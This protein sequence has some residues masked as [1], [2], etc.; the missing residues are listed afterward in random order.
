M[1][2]LQIY[3]GDQIN[4]GATTWWERFDA[5]DDYTTSLSHGWGGS[6]TWFLTTYL[7]GAK[8]LGPNIWLVRPALTG[9]PQVSGKIPLR[10][11]ELQAHWEVYNDQDSMVEITAS[12]GSGGEIVVPYNDPTLILTLNGELIWKSQE[13]LVEDVY[14]TPGEIHILIPGG[15]YTLLIHQD[16]N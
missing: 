7:L 15:Q 13:A 8:R 2:I 14:E 10:D 5:Q 9:V 3:Y 1:N 12:E 11:G 4:S 6:P 16:D